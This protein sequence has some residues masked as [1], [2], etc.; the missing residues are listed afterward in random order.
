MRL[1]L[2]QSQLAPYATQPTMPFAAPSCEQHTVTVSTVG[3]CQRLNHGGPST[4]L[5]RLQC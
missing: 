3:S 4:L 1:G 5:V 2:L